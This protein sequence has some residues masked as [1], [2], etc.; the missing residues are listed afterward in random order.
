MALQVQVVYSVIEATLPDGSY[1]IT[2]VDSKGFQAFHSN[3]ATRDLALEG[4]TNYGFTVSEG[5]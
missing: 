2:L 1:R 4:L 3:G 5:E